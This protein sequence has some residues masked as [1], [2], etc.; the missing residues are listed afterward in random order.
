MLE[1]EP[2]TE[3]YRPKTLDEFIFPV[4]FSDAE[5]EKFKQY[6][7]NRF[8][9]QNYIFF[10]KGGTGKSTLANILVKEITTLNER[11]FYKVT[12]R[13]I[14]DIDKLKAWI[15]QSPVS[16]KVKLVVIEEIDR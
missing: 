9:D 2:W 6:V 12:G 15:K 10:G 13:R 1:I 14:D 7:K 11:N 5:I 16:S 3:K 4:D 8:I